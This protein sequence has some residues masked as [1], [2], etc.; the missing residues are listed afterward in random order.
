MSLGGFTTPF[1]KN[2]Y[3]N[4]SQAT[5]FDGIELLPGAGTTT[6]NYTI[7]GYGKSL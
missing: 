6:G 3:G 5:I 1:I 4:Q 7:Y 2:N